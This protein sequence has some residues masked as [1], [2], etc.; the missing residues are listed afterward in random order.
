MA[1]ESLP[2][3]PA[4][5]ASP[6]APVAIDPDI[7]PTSFHVRTHA[8]TAI[9]YAV[10]AA[11]AAALHS[12]P[13]ASLWLW[14]N[15]V[16][17]VLLLF[18]VSLFAMQTLPRLP[19]W[20]VAFVATMT[21][22]QSVTLGVASE[23]VFG[24]YVM[25]PSAP[26]F[27]AAAAQLVLLA[28]VGERVGA[29]TSARWHRVLLAALGAGAITASAVAIAWRAERSLAIAIGAGVV[30]T[31][32]VVTSDHARSR[33]LAR[34]AKD[35]NPDHATIRASALLVFDVVYVFAR[36]PRLRWP[37]GWWPRRTS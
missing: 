27:L 10:A 18:A 35:R 3:A 28:G 37:A 31:S 6:P 13:A 21:A 36:L 16:C 33:A 34:I 26:V 12:T 22:V 29:G 23:C 20:P 8:L 2:R 7:L 19:K 30:V 32:I 1:G 17:V 14:M 24:R 4:F 25:A 5:V 11:S 9:W 15:P